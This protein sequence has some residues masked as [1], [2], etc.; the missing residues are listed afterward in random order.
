MCDCPE[1]CKPSDAELKKPLVNLIHCGGR[2]ALY[3]NG[4]LEMVADVDDGNAC[5]LILRAIARTGL[6]TVFPRWPE[7]SEILNE[8]GQFPAYYDCR[9]CAR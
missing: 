3:I 9:K 7:P 1:H 6:I 8:V 5:D 4:K 2:Y